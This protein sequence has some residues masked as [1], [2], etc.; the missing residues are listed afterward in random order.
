MSAAKPNSFTL[1]ANPVV[2]KRETEESADQSVRKRLATPNS[3]PTQRV[4]SAMNI[5]TFEQAQLF[6]IGVEQVR[7]AADHPVVNR[8]ST[9]AART[10][11]V[12]APSRHTTGA[13]CIASQPWWRLRLRP[14]KRG[15]SYCSAHSRKLL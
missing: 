10:S 8:A 5:E 7:G 2:R 9:C 3:L 6:D 4:A 13:R 12:A 1:S 15:L 11:T 14:L